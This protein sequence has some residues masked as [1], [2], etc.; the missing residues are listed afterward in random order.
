[1]SEY[2]EDVCYYCEERKLCKLWV[3][4]KRDGSM[5][6]CETVCKVCEDKWIYGHN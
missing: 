2:T 3:T 1:M 4:F 5:E 6:F